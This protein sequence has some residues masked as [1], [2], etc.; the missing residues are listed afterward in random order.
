MLAQRFIRSLMGR[1][2]GWCVHIALSCVGLHV[3]D[4][5][6]RSRGCGSVRVCFDR[7]FVLFSLLSSFFL[8]F[9]LAAAV[10]LM[11]ESDQDTMHEAET[12]GSSARYG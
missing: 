8:S 11:S 6:A 3:F 5:S 7:G 4:V 10:R 2:L 12:E 9:L 1:D